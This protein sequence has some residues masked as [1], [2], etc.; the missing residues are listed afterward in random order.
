MKRRLGLKTKQTLVT[1][2]YEYSRKQIM[3]GQ[4]AYGK[5]FLSAAMLC[6]YYSI[7]MRTAK[8]VLQRLK[9]DGLIRAE[10]RKRSVVIYQLPLLD[11]GLMEIGLVLRQKNTTLAVCR[12]IESIMPELLAFYVPFCNALALEHYEVALEWKNKKQLQGR[13]R[14]ASHLFHDVLCATGNLLASTMYA[15]L[16]THAQ[17]PYLYDYQAAFTGFSLY[18]DNNDVSAIITQYQKQNRQAIHNG[19][20]KSFHTAMLSI[21][22]SF[23]MLSDTYPDFPVDSEIHYTWNAEHVRLPLYMRVA[24][25]IINKIGTGYYPCGSFLPPERELAKQ[26]GMSVYTIREALRRLNDLGFGLTYKSKGTQVGFPSAE[27]SY[28]TINNKEYQRD[29]MLYLSALQLMALLIR[30]AA[31][32]VFDQIGKKDRL[33]IQERFAT[34]GCPPLDVLFQ[35]IIDRLDLQPFKTIL[36][37]L[38]ELLNWGYYFSL[39]QGSDRSLSPLHRISMNAFHRLQENDRKGF[40]VGLCECYCHI[41]TCSRNFVVKQGLHEAKKIKTP[42]PLP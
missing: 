17:L 25:D 41:L 6:Q 21:R 30:P 31:L 11:D 20:Y 37:E 34:A 9:E 14:T 33:E 3:S 42:E 16:E 1:L 39:F 19:F 23:K 32:L 26:Y 8:A 12:T 4:W 24:R 28:R 18:D 35:C 15:S 36:L 22:R 38:H 13:W 10:E 27:I 40:A 7:S 5:P 2:V 29:I